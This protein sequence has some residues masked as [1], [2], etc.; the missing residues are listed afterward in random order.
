MTFASMKRLSPG[1][2]FCQFPGNFFAYNNILISLKKDVVR[3]LL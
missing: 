2:F 3:N 1:T